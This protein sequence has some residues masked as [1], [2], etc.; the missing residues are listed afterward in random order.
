MTDK[1]FRSAAHGH[2]VHEIF[3]GVREVQTVE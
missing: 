2:L 3:R 1:E